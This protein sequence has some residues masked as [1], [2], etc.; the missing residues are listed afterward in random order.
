[1]SSLEG[2]LEDLKQDFVDIS[3]SKSI[4]LKFDMI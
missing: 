2:L 4:S 3:E 1:M